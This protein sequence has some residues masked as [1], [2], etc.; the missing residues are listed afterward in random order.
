MLHRLGKVMSSTFERAIGRW[1]RRMR[2]GD[3]HLACNDPQIGASS[4]DI[5]LSS[6][7]FADGAAIP[8]RHARVDLGGNLSPPLEW[9]GVPPWT[10]ELV[11]VMQDPDAPF[12]RP[13]VHLIATGIP[14]NCGA[15][16]DGYLS[17]NTN[18]KIAFGRG[19]FGRVG[20]AGP[21]PLRGHG[22]HRYVFQIFALASR[23]RVAAM[24]DLFA[25]KSARSGFVLAHGRLSGT[26]ERQ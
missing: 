7:A 5:L 26:Y 23:L 20:Y 13:L 22:P 14:G 8:D 21:R 11:L 2:A 17:P 9:T 15:V 4:A 6:A 24:A 18:Q 16:G 10:A 25:T 19:S 12:P 1:V 3:R